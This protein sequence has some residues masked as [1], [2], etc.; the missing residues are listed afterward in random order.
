M[1]FGLIGDGKIAHR[2]RH[3]IEENGGRIIRVH[4]PKYEKRAIL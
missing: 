1:R 3:A 2:H 4:D